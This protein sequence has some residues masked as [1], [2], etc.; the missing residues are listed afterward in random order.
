M[1]WKD[2]YLLAVLALGFVLTE[3]MGRAQHT[4]VPKRQGQTSQTHGATTP[5]KP[6]AHPPAGNAVSPPSNAVTNPGVPPLTG[7]A[8]KVPHTRLTITK[9]VNTSFPPIARAGGGKQGTANGGT[10]TGSS[11]FSDLTGVS[12]SHDTNVIGFRDG[13]NQQTQVV[14]KGQ[15][16]GGSRVRTQA[17]TLPANAVQGTPTN[18]PKRK[19]PATPPHQR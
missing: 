14:P 8:D 3:P 1:T 17:A 18:P 6:A 11:G 10:S 13:S 19:K 15:P 4:N 7:S 16:A 12:Q 5:K 2:G 9:R